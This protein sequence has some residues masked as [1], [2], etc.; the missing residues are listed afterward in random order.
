MAHPNENALWSYGLD[1]QRRWTWTG[2][3]RLEGIEQSPD[4]DELVVAAGPRETDQRRD[5]YGALVFDLDAPEGSGAER[6]RALCATEGPAFFRPALSADGR[7]AVAEHPFPDGA[8]GV[9][10]AYRVTV[11]R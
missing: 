6:L 8:G 1:G 10:G 3:H 9:A 7:V 5:L 11:L 2:E 4:G